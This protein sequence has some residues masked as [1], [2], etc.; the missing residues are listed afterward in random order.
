M[1]R[2]GG[3]EEKKTKKRWDEREE[4]GRIYRRKTNSIKNK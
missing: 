3:K 2:E 4:T 1:E